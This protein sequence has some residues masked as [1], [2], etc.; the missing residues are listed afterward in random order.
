MELHCYMHDPD[1]YVSDGNGSL[2]MIVKGD[3]RIGA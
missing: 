2:R 3:D 1:G